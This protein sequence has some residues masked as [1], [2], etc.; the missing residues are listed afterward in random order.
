MIENAIALIA[1][2]MVYDDTAIMRGQFLWFKSKGQSRTVHKNQCVIVISHVAIKAVDF[3]Q[4]GKLLLHWRLYIIIDFFTTFFQPQ[5][6]SNGGTNSIA[7]RF[8]MSHDQK[9]I[10]SFQIICNFL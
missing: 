1:L 8:L 3:W 7:I 10:M 6:Q 5:S 2:M 9:T 4:P